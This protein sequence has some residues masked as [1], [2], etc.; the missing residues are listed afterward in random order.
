[1]DGDWFACQACGQRVEV[2]EMIRYALSAERP[3]VCG[4]CGARHVFDASL[5]LDQ[6]WVREKL[7]ELG[8]LRNADEPGSSPGQSTPG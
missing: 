3:G 1:M 2:P 5:R 7:D 8:R 4:G 6:S